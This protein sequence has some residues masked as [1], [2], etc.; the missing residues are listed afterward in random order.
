MTSGCK[1]PIQL[2]P[3]W[4]RRGRH[5]ASDRAGR[6]GV[7]PSVRALA[8]TMVGAAVLAGCGSKREPA[9]SAQR[10]GANSTVMLEVEN[11]HYLDAA[12]YVGGT[13]RRPQRIGLATASQSTV[14]HFSPRHLGPGGELR[15]IA[16]AVGTTGG[17]LSSEPLI[18]RPGQRVVWTIERNFQVSSA[19]VW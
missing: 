3:G 14:L 18:V 19:A 9:Q 11:R 4:A 2:R 6:R 8:L 5:G 13:G 12:I 17:R 10:W 7:L 15:L 1:P 16:D